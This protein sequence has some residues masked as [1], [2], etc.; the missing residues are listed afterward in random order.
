[1]SRMSGVGRV[2]RAQDW[3][4]P[5]LDGD[6]TTGRPIHEI[7]SERDHWQ[8]QYENAYRELERLR[9]ITQR[10][11]EGSCEYLSEDQRKCG[12]WLINGEVL[13]CWPCQVRAVLE[14]RWDG[15]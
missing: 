15:R 7:K 8:L 11:A 6:Y 9:R 10:V 12:E 14:G 1:M 3:T 13:W 4:E 2:K 5:G